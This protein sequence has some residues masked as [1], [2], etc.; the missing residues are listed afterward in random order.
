M[1]KTYMCPETAYLQGE[2]EEMIATSVEGFS[3]QLDD[4][5]P[6]GTDDM[7]SR[8]RTVWD[9]DDLDDGDL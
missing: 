7:L 2:T 3:G 4:D 9:S 5:N 6:I 8:R 1:K